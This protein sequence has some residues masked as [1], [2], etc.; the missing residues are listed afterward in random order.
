MGL[1]RHLGRSISDPEVDRAATG[2]G[3][4]DIT[5]PKLSIA[6]GKGINIL[7]WSKVTAWFK[8]V[9]A[10]WD[11]VG[12]PVPMA[13]GSSAWQDPS[14]TMWGNQQWK[15]SRSLSLHTA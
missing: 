15:A 3:R 5:T 10:L 9:Q 1:S 11:S 8:L 14:P 12:V 4:N 2:V 7:R 13:P 6:I